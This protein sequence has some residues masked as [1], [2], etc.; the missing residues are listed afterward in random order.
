MEYPSL[1]AHPSPGQARATCGSIV[2]S[3]SRSCSRD[4]R[5]V[6]RLQIHPRLRIDAEKY[7]EA[8]RRIG[9]DRPLAVH[10]F[11]DA[12]RRHT[13]RLGERVLAYT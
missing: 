6:L 5:V 1:C 8:H 2:R 9:G 4:F 12:P 11:I 7:R 13:D 10:D 3:T